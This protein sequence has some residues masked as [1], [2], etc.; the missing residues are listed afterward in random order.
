MK[1]KSS[2]NYEVS[3]GVT[4]ASLMGAISLFFTGVLLAQ[5]KSFD[6]TIRIPLLFLVIST[7]SYIFAAS[8]Y[9]NAGI[10]ITVD[11]IPKVKKY[12]IYANNIFEFLGLYLLILATPLVVGAVT[13]D[14]FLKVATII[15]ALGGLTLYSLSSFSV[16][17]KEVR[18]PFWKVVITGAF[19]VLGLLL[20][21]SQNFEQVSRLLAYNYLAT[22]LIV[23]TLLVT[24]AFCRNSSQYKVD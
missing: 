8:I 23:V 3:V 6:S 14:N 24:I 15:V 21:F 17:H 9:S 19:V 4:F 10:E 18:N 11:D 5:Y 22:A 20:Y 13:H 1:D 12:L 16:L 2:L 7:F